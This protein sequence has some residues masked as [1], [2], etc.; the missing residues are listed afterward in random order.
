MA[1]F[2]GRIVGTRFGPTECEDFDE[3]LSWVSQVGSLRDYQKDFGK[4]RITI[5]AGRLDAEV[6]GGGLGGLKSEITEGIRMSKPKSSKEAISFVRMRKSTTLT[7]GA[8]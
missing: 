7:M 8:H 4:L 5:I 3:A 6:V 2:W 1:D